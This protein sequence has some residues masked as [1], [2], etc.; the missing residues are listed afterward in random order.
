MKSN[1]KFHENFPSKPPKTK[2]FKKNLIFNDVEYLWKLTTMFFITNI[3][4]IMWLNP[5]TII[6]TVTFFTIWNMNIVFAC[7]H[8]LWKKN[9]QKLESSKH[10][11]VLW[12]NAI[13]NR[14][15]D[16]SIANKVHVSLSARNLMNMCWL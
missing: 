13:K 11:N 1:Q 16:N 10:A 14:K 8:F 5:T 9:K 7:K 2:R 15:R 3:V 12:C 4:K 6:N